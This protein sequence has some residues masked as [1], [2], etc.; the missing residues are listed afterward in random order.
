[1]QQ[2]IQIKIESF[3]AIE[4]LL[5]ENLLLV[6]PSHS[7]VKDVLDEIVLLHDQKLEVLGNDKLQSQDFEKEIVT[8][9]SEEH[10]NDALS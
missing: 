10:D 6:C 1:M 2:S 4:K 8:I 5:P 3:G 9:L 7:L